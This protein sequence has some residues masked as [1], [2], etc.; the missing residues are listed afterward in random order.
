MKA[1]CNT[2]IMLE[3][4]AVKKAPIGDVL[5]RKKNKATMTM[6]CNNQPENADGTMKPAIQQEVPPALG[7]SE[8]HAG[9]TC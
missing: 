6:T 2:A 5:V 7:P 1:E 9:E 4:S 3:E 8:E